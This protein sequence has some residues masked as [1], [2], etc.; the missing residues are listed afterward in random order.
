MEQAQ[1]RESAAI[2]EGHQQA[3]PTAESGAGGENLAT[4][5][6]LLFGAQLAQRHDAGAVLIAQW[7]MQ[8]QIKQPL[9]AE[10]GEFLRKTGPY[11]L[12]CGYRL[13]GINE[14]RHR[15]P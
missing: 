5:Q 15:A 10:S 1:I 6:G 13:L 4:D 11:A 14:L 9:D 8:E 3:A 7:E 2:F 12:E